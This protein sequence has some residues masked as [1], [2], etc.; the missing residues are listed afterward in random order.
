MQGD[1]ASTTITLCHNYAHADSLYCARGAS[2]MRCTGN[3]LQATKNMFVKQ[4]P[5]LTQL[6]S[7]PPC[8]F[9]YPYSIDYESLAI[10]LGCYSTTL[11][12]FLK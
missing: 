2:L 7:V 10:I 1:F 11:V 3:V 5:K 8:T 12:I 6:L 9:Y 4:P